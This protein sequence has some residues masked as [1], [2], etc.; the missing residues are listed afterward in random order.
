MNVTC[1]NG[2]Q[3]EDRLNGFYCNCSNGYDGEYCEQRICEYEKGVCL[4]NTGNCDG[5]TNTSFSCGNRG[6]CC[7]SEPIEC[8]VRKADIVFLFDASG[9]VGSENFATGLGFMASIVNYWQIGPEHIQV[10][11]IS[12]SNNAKVEVSLGQFTDNTQLQEAIRNIFYYKGKTYTDLALKLLNQIIQRD[13]RPDVPRVGIVITDGKSTNSGAT[14]AAARLVQQNKVTLFS[15]G[16]GGGVD[17]DE[18]RVIAGNASRVFDVNNYNLLEE[19]RKLVA[20]DVCDV[21]NNTWQDVDQCYGVVCENGGTLKCVPANNTAECICPKGFSGTFCEIDIDYCPG[22]TCQ[23]GGDCIELQDGFRCRCPAAYTGTFCE[24]KAVIGTCIGYGDPHYK[25]FDKQIIHFQGTCKYNLAKSCG[26]S[27]ANLTDFLVSVENEHRRGKKVSWLRQVEI[28][29]FGNVIRFEK[30][31]RIFINDKR[32]QLPA[33]LASGRVSL[34]K[35]K[36]KT[37]HLVTDFGMK[38]EY[39]GRSKVEVQIPGQYQNLMCGI[40]G[41]FNGNKAD[42]FLL[43]NGTNVNDRKRKE[44][45]ALVGNSYEIPGAGIPG[46]KK[47]SEDDWIECTDS[48]R[49]LVSSTNYCGLIND[50]SSVFRQCINSGNLDIEEIKFS[51]EFD[52]CESFAYGISAAK[53]TASERLEGFAS[54]CAEYGIYVKWRNAANCY[55]ICGKDEVYDAMAPACPATCNTPADKCTVAGTVEDCRCK[56]GYVLSGDT[57]VPEDQCGCTDGQGIYYMLGHSWISENCTVKHECVREN[58]TS[59]IR[60]THLPSCDVNARC[61]LKN[62]IRGCYCNWPYRGDGYTCRATKT[63][64]IYGDPHY[65]TFDGVKI[66]FQ[67]TCRYDAAKSCLASGSNLTNFRVTVQQE[68]RGRSKKVSFTRNIEV[69]VGNHVIT[70][71]KRRVVLVDGQKESLPRVLNIDGGK[72][73]IRRLSKKRVRVRTTFGLNVIFDGNTKASVRVPAEYMNQMCGICGNYNGDKTDD[74]RLADGTDVSGG[75]KRDIFAQIGNSYLVPDPSTIGCQAGSPDDW[76]ECVGGQNA[77]VDNDGHCGTMNKSD[78]VFSSCVESGVVD[79]AQLYADC[80]F[81]V[82]HELIYVDESSAKEAA[83]EAL[84]NMADQCAAADQAVT[85]RAATNCPLSCGT[86]QEFNPTASACPATCQ[87]PNAPDEC[88]GIPVEDCECK[89][90]YLLSGDTCVAADQCGCS[91][92]EGNYYELGES[93]LSTDCLTHYACVHENGTSFIK[94]TNRSSCDANAQCTLLNGKRGCYCTPPYEGDGYS[95]IETGSCISSL[96]NFVT[97]DE[98]AYQFNGTCKYMLASSCG[99]LTAEQMRFTVLQNNGPLGLGVEVN[100]YNHVVTLGPGEMVWVDGLKINYLPRMIADEKVKI[101][102]L[103]GGQVRL[104]SGPGFEVM[105]NGNSAAI[106]VPAEY[107]N[108]VC[109]LCGNFNGDKMDDLLLRNGTNISNGRSPSEIWALVAGSYEVSGGAAGCRPGNPIPPG[110]CTAEQLI[111]VTSSE[112]C[113]LINDTTSVFSQCINSGYLQ[114]VRIYQACVSD[115]CGGLKNSVALAKVKACNH[116]DSFASLCSS[117]KFPVIWRQA[118]NCPLTCQA[119]E[120]YDSTSSACPATCQ[121]PQAPEKCN[122]ATVERCR[123]KEGYLLSG[124]T[125]VPED[126]CGCSDDEGNYYALGQSWLSSDCAIQYQCKKVDVESVIVTGDRRPCH[127]NGKCGMVDFARKCICPPPYSGDGYSCIA[128]NV[129]AEET[130][131]FSRGGHVLVAC[132]RTGNWSETVIASWSIYNTDRMEWI[133]VMPGNKYEI[134]TTGL[135]IKNSTDKDS[136]LYRCAASEGNFTADTEI[137]VKIGGLPE[138]WGPPTSGAVAEGDNVTLTCFGEGISTIMWYKGMVESPLTASSKYSLSSNGH[139]LTILAAAAEDDDMY[140]C[141]ARNSYGTIRSQATLT[142]IAPVAPYYKI[143]LN[144]TFTSQNNSHAVLPTDCMSYYISHIYE[145]FTST[146]Q[147]SIGVVE[148]MP[149]CS[150]LVNLTLEMGNVDLSNNVTEAYF[151]GEIVL[152]SPKP[153]RQMET[154]GFALSTIL[155]LPISPVAKFIK[156]NDS[157]ECVGIE[158]NPPSLHEGGKMWMCPAGHNFIESALE[159]PYVTN[160]TDIT[161]TRPPPTV[162][163]VEEQPGVCTAFSGINYMTLDGQIISFQGTAKYQFISL[164]G[165][166]SDMNRFQV[167]TRTE[168][169]VG[170]SRMEYKIIVE[171]SV[172][173]NTIV[174]GIGKSVKV[175]SELVLALPYTIPGTGVNITYN[176]QGQIQLVT[177]AGFM[178]TY[179]GDQMLK[180]MVPRK[181]ASGTC[182]ICGNFDGDK[183]N[184]LRLANGTDVS[185]VGENIQNVYAQIGNSYRILDLQFSHFGEAEPVPNITCT[186]DQLDMAKTTEYCGLL[187]DSSSVF[188]EC[189]HNA[190]IDIEGMY[191]LCQADVCAEL[192]VNNTG[193]AKQMACKVLETF[194]S[195]CRRYGYTEAW[196]SVSNCSLSCGPNEV[197]STST[198]SC[199]ATCHSPNA[200]GDCTSLPTEGCACEDGYIRS[201]YR[202]VPE[203]ECGCTDSFGNYHELN[204]YWMSE[205]CSTWHGCELRMG[206]PSIVANNASCNSQSEC[207]VVD[208]IRGCYCAAEDDIGSGDMCTAGSTC[209]AYGDPH[210]ITF[211][212]TFMSFRGNCTYNFVLP[213]S[214]TDYPVNIFVT[215][216]SEDKGL[217]IAP[218]ERVEVE[219]TGLPNVKIHKDYTVQVGGI[220]RTVPFS[221]QRENDRHNVYMG[222]QNTIYVESLWQNSTGDSLILVMG[223]NKQL[224]KVSISLPTVRFSEKLTGLCGNFN[225]LKE[226]DLYLRNGS[227]VTSNRNLT[228]EEIYSMVS[229]SYMLSQSCAQETADFQCSENEMQLAAT[230]KFCGL[231]KNNRSAAFASCIMSGKVDVD[232]MYYACTKDV[233]KALRNGDSETAKAAACRSLKVLAAQCPRTTYGEQYWTLAQCE[234]S[235]GED[236]VFRSST[237]ACPATCANPVAP[238]TCKKANVAGCMC[239]PGYLLSGTKC[240]PKSHCGCVDSWG[241]YH[242]TFMSFRGNCTYNFVLPLSNTDYPV[243]IFVTYESEDKGLDIAPIERVEVEFTGLPNVKIH[244]DYTVQNSTGDTLILVMGFNKQLGKVSISLPTVRFS[245]KLTG[246][247]GNFNGLKEDDIYLRNGSAVTSNSNLTKEEIYSMVS[248]SYM[249]SESCAQETADFQCSENEMQLAATTKFCGL[250]KNNRSAA[251]ASCIMSGIVDVD[252]MYYACTKDVCKALRNGDSETAKAAACRSLKVLAAQCPRTTYGEQYWTLAQC[253]PSCGEDEVFRSSTSACPATCANPVAPLTCKKANVA[254]CMC[255]PGYLLSGTKCIPKSHCG[256][257]DSWGNYHQLGEKWMSVNCSMQWNCEKV[258]GTAVITDTSVQCDSNA[259]CSV[260]EGTRNCFCRS[261]YTGNGFTCTGPYVDAPSPQYLVVNSDDTIQ[262]RAVGLWTPP[263]GMQFTKDSAIVLTEG[264]K[265]MVNSSRGLMIMNISTAD[266]GSYICSVNDSAGVRDTATVDVYTGALPVLWSTPQDS[267][268]AYGDNVT[269]SCYGNGDSVLWYKG[270]TS[271]EIIESSEN[272]VL[273]FSNATLTILSADENAV[274]TY[275]CTSSNVFGTV[276]Y[277]ANVTVIAPAIP[278]FL[279]SFNGTMGSNNASQPILPYAC[280]DTFTQSIRAILDDTYPETA[281]IFALLPEC[282]GIPGVQLKNTGEILVNASNTTEAY[283]YAETVVTAT[284]ISMALETCGRTISDLLTSVTSVSPASLYLFT[285]DTVDCPGIQLSPGY[286]SDAG[287]KWTCPQGYVFSMVPFQCTFLSVLPTVPVITAPI[288][289]TAPIE[290]SSQEAEALVSIHN[291]NRST[292]ATLMQA[293]DMRTLVWA[294]YLADRVAA[295]LVAMCNMSAVGSVITEQGESIGLITLDISNQTLVEG[296]LALYEDWISTQPQ[297]EVT[298]CKE[299]PYKLVWS[300]ASRMGCALRNCL[301]GV[302]QAVCAYAPG[303]PAPAAGGVY[304]EMPFKNGTPC[305]ACNT[306]DDNREACLVADKL[307]AT[308]PY[309]QAKNLSCALCGGFTCKNGQPMNYTTCTCQCS[310]AYTGLRCENVTCEEVLTCQNEGTFSYDSCSCSCSK[311]YI[312]KTCDQFDCNTYNIDSWAFC[313]NFSENCNSVLPG[314]DIIRHICP[315]TCKMCPVPSGRKKRSITQPLLSSQ[316]VGNITI[317]RTT[318]GNGTN[319]VVIGDNSTVAV[320]PLVLVWNDTFPTCLDIKPPVF[321]VCPENINITLGVNG[322]EEVTFDMP[323]AEDNSGL[324][325]ITSLPPRVISPY[326]FKKNMTVT[327]TAEDPSGNAANCTVNVVLIDIHPP[328]M[329]CPA[330]PVMVNVTTDVQQ[331]P[332]S[333]PLDT[334]Q[335]RDYSGIASVVYD[336]PN[337]T[338]VIV[339]EPMTVTVTTIDA[340]GNNASCTFIFL[341]EPAGCPDWTLIPPQNGNKSCVSDKLPSGL[342]ALLCTILCEGPRYSLTVEDPGPSQCTSGGLW[343]PSPFLPDCSFLNLPEFTIQITLDFTVPSLAGCTPTYEASVIE[344][345]TQLALTSCSGFGELNKTSK[346]LGSSALTNGLRLDTSIDLSFIDPTADIQASQ[347]E[348]CAELISN[349]LLSSTALT[350]INVTTSGCNDLNLDGVPNITKG[351]SCPM[352]QVVTVKNGS[353]FCAECSAGFY[354]FNGTCM[355]CPRGTYQDQFGQTNCTVC[356]SGTSTRYDGAKNLTDCIAYCGQ[357]EF[358]KNALQPCSRCEVGSY[359]PNT[360]SKDCIMCSAGTTTQFAG[361]VLEKECKAVCNPGTFSSSGLVPCIPCPRHTFADLFGSTVC[362]ECSEQLATVS[363]GSNKSSDCKVID[364][365]TPSKCQNDGT[366]N[367]FSRYYTCLCSLGFTGKNCETN[368]DECSS[369]DCQN[370]A[371]CVDGIGSYICTCPPGF[372]GRFCE[373]P[374]DECASNPCMFGEC[375]DGFLSYDCACFQGYTGARCESP[376]DYCQS[377]PC[378]NNGQCFNAENTYECVCEGTGFQ[379]PQ[380]TIPID[381]CLTM[382]CQ[383]DGNCTDAINDIIC[384]CPPGFAGQYCE[385]EEDE[386]SSNPCMNLAACKDLTNNYQCDCKPGFTGR[387]C[388]V[389]I[390]ECDPNKCQNNATCMDELN[391]FSCKC[392][393]GYEG[394]LCENKINYCLD[395]PCNS[396]GSCVNGIDTYTCLCSSGWTGKDCGTNIDDCSPDPCVNGKCIDQLRGYYCD[397]DRGYTGKNCSDIIDNCDKGSCLNGANCTSVLNGFTCTCNSGWTGQLCES[398]IQ[399]CAPDTCLNGGSCDDGINEFF[400]SCPDGFTGNRCQIN[401]NECLSGPCENGGFCTD[402]VDGYS[403]SCAAGFTGKDCKINIDDCSP[404]PCQRGAECIDKVSDFACVCPTSYTGKTCAD[405]VDYC[406]VLN[407][408]PK[409]ATCVN[410]VK[411]NGATCRC[412]PGTYGLVCEKESSSDFDILFQGTAACSAQGIA[413]STMTELS[414]CLWVRY[415]SDT[416][417][418]PHFE[419]YGNGEPILL[420]DSSKTYLNITGTV[421]EVDTAVSTGAW[422]HQCAT[423]S[424]T[425][426]AWSVYLNGQLVQSGTGYGVSSV[427]STSMSI[428]MAFGARGAGILSQVNVFSTSLLASRIAT[429]GNTFSVLQGT[430]AMLPW[431]YL[432]QFGY[433]CNAVEIL[434]P[435]IGGT[436]VCPPGFRGASCK[437]PID[438]DPPVVTY[439]PIDQTIVYKGYGRAQV[440]WEEPRF[441]DNVGVVKIDRPYRRGASLSWGRYAIQYTACDAE[442]N[443]ASCSFMVV[444]TTSYCEPFPAPKNGYKECTARKKHKKKGHNHKK[445]G[446]YYKCKLKCNKGYKFNKADKPAKYYTCGEDGSWSYKKKRGAPFRVPACSPYKKPN[447]RI[448]GRAKHK[449]KSSADCTN[450]EKVDVMES[451]KKGCKR[452]LKYHKY[453]TDCGRGKYGC[454]FNVNVNCGRGSARLKRQAQN[455]SFYEVTYDLTA[456]PNDTDA[457]NETEQSESIVSAFTR[458]VKYGLLTYD[459]D[460]TT[461]VADSSTIIVD[462]ILLCPEGSTLDGNDC[463]DCPV[464]MYYENTTGVAQCLP[465]PVGSYSNETGQLDCTQCPVEYNVTENVQSVNETDCYKSCPAGSYY[466]ESQDS[467]VKCPIG[468]YQDKV[469]QK[470]CRGCDS[471]TTTQQIGAHEASLC[472]ACPPGTDL[473]VNGTCEACPM[474]TYKN[475]S[476]SITCQVCPVGTTTNFTGATDMDQCHVI[477]TTPELPTTTESATTE[478]ASTEAPGTVSTMTIPTSATDGTTVSTPTTATDRTTVTTTTPGTDST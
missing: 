91:D 98:E 122:E 427:I 354:A 45:Y 230:T 25:T 450:K 181:Y 305:S 297:C 302:H 77:I 454:Q 123:C 366:C 476:V 318:D 9:S 188:S 163:P 341:I 11:V 62:G 53:A 173:N 107:R 298:P 348:Q 393:P 40:C 197:Y 358:S 470:F 268:V 247:C 171:T 115:V 155:T 445:Y 368:I 258:N 461:V 135:I 95:C 97:F 101:E 57:C 275:V 137:Q 149:Q 239:K 184:D 206:Q 32:V 240:I 164:C 100:I 334:V 1:Q 81:D 21:T 99:N 150:N 96:T 449:R 440:N 42:D 105:F 221:L 243:N 119:N 457:D 176:S 251:F 267:H 39:N 261:P 446:D 52:V 12:F 383:N 20:V 22:V 342:D 304:N 452:R 50:T 29:V 419:L 199:P 227:A 15:I 467:C 294:E 472:I 374:I 72:I 61:K 139:A 242:Q 291:A 362:Q 126:Q 10:G 140:I 272:I 351:Y 432:G 460:N 377:R 350:V 213:L 104:S 395:E 336:P 401:I 308:Q 83:C 80:R 303:P 337:G 201:G 177:T 468:F 373:V 442:N 156:V 424:S 430:G 394:R 215:Y 207:R 277:S 473:S 312:G 186:V 266:A 340:A 339:G 175:N 325:S 129:T 331:V 417:D 236:E 67:G 218:I 443:C 406:S 283:F 425:S 152:R 478:T 365:C 64:W 299:D 179:D 159:C 118:A 35:I 359:Q 214:N 330:N 416:V 403:C 2:G 208:G 292:V 388:E 364:Q 194:A 345:L 414:V 56:D 132:Q 320:Q 378:A 466:E 426:G 116:L 428:K 448:K 238:L 415:L 390:D 51:C 357:G 456:A 5:T 141:V 43:A 322:P 439:C 376:V 30:K 252:Q 402:L 284:S 405:I 435:S 386:C 344:A 246:L 361:A 296:I 301:N 17:R 367:S 355:K 130:Q 127:P 63:C 270:S 48:Q 144:G 316:N 138:V 79:V 256:C 475:V 231:I 382:S 356:P 54:R 387:N 103:T 441:T 347:T 459:V 259:E 24:T 404:N 174:F 210:L 190:N 212:Q 37:V 78:N 313:A 131:Y 222:P 255:K 157:N 311:F 421:Q 282:G 225:G 33:T 420:F 335:I 19:V 477:A 34:I 379:G 232:Q 117:N 26:A 178:V 220:T 65:K 234:P 310:V 124:A 380:C 287:M 86:N 462:G 189:I 263:L 265:Y 248:K 142:V 204:E 200:A 327:Y 7:F 223:F 73:R 180:V 4:R 68:H 269:L 306:D 233:C 333:Y 71:K 158:L 154:C 451:F 74:L 409:N 202:C 253:E 46:C 464:G 241:N 170:I 69:T 385:L 134:G 84:S 343:S 400:C 288:P 278:S 326:M 172:D 195:E 14:K 6:T 392:S 398:N 437:T 198:T 187:R 143:L 87:N 262:C 307:C 469:N 44:A 110:T 471:G 219:F 108:R 321:T 182:G 463:V 274:G 147:A 286:L 412:P 264:D 191:S 329:Y 94:T 372:T 244:K 167:A 285:Q 408:C 281:S 162:P 413:I 136:G 85:W 276:T 324:V 279:L 229:K 418:R 332:A 8:L 31:G 474:G 422:F 399:D 249:L 102:L 369:N 192:G 120:E 254:G 90:G 75:R 434:V 41:N 453:T 23:N 166:S 58:G 59:F 38:I 323:Q 111:N 27:Q 411:E 375:T 353:S 396:R 444:V 55:P 216:E 112:Y 431:S 161:T 260:R 47:G 70:L 217:D 133:S 93:W 106:R 165:V 28:E 209:M 300:K 114:T 328:V 196:R 314:G 3:C 447:C 289:T 273:K 211:D 465:C 349:A 128:P 224:G 168:T 185:N 315:I 76:V 228:K 92:A 433:F 145:L 121:N 16:V 49:E 410:S 317:N 436:L 407:P 295:R 370:N 169:T 391:D 113:G 455:D 290:I 36:R 352:G 458:D 360:G 203:S 429:W 389:N 309:C 148:K 319:N 245:E 193:R 88:E 125:C 363:M 183:T 82:C 226:D 60:D 13:G 235:C 18:L 146:L 397:C 151:S 346:S 371:T 438:R 160:I 271:G 423:W 338:M 280:R 205:D 89:E 250:I 66:N 153:T 293:A 257:V 381:D 237:S 109:G 384:S